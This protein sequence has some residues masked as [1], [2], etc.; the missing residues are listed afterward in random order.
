MRPSAFASIVCFGV[1]PI[2]CGGARSSS[3]ASPTAVSRSVPFV[4][5]LD[6]NRNSQLDAF[7]SLRIP[8]VEVTFGGAAGKTSVTTGEVTLTVAQTA[9]S[10][11]VSSSTLPPYYRAPD[12]AFVAPP[13]AGPVAVPITLPLGP[14]ATP[15][16]YLAFGD[17]ITN[18]Q[19]AVGDGQGY[20]G[21]LERMLSAHFGRARL[22]SDG[23]D[24][25]SSERGD[26][27][28]LVSL[29]AGRPAFTLIQYGT[30]D[31]SDPRC[32]EPPCFT[33]ERLRSMVRKVKAS[34]GFAF[35]GTLLMT[36]VG[37]DFRAS[38]QRNAWV[39]EQ[40]TLIRRMAI[41]EDVVLVDLHAAFERSPSSYAEL[42]ADYI[43][44]SAAGY[45]VIADAWF[46]AITARP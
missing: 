38:P 36:N 14:G 25:S 40:N 33:I 4:A 39:L 6:E 8:G 27:R 26:D 21:Q 15:G 7:E 42:F 29:A 2:A 35:V 20:I 32:F 19:A 44:P 9:Q 28:I 46:E 18:G 24:S 11:T 22:I 1:L 23:L 5:F 34:G 37:N 3:P 13:T 17:S 43:H 10:L 16:I 31:W 30:N 12:P 41:E 45:R